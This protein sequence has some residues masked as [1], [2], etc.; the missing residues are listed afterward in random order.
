ME[1]LHRNTIAAVET[2]YSTR[3]VGIEKTV[4]PVNLL[5]N[6][7]DSGRSR[8]AIENPAVLLRAGQKLIA[9]GATALAVCCLM[10]DCEDETE[11]TAYKSGLGVDP[12]SGLEAMISH[13]LVSA[14]KVPAAHA[15]VFPY[16][17]ALPIIDRLVDP[18]AASEFIV[19]T[20][21]P[22][23]LTGLAK[24]PQF[25]A[26][27]STQHGMTIKDLSALLVPEDALGSIPVLAALEKQI[28]VLTIRNN[29]TVMQATPTALGIQDRI[30]SCTNYKEALGQLIA[31]RTG[32]T[33]PAHF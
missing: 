24:A 14:F 4:E 16:E 17:A 32:I 31:L 21:L 26:T 12:I 10:P 2:V 7:G 29:Q 1:I 5:L 23:V 8:G 11:E 15:P 25:T 20:F 19:S 18:R 30:I 13:L 6:K 33:L 28:P 27:H 22:C 3:I 9:Q